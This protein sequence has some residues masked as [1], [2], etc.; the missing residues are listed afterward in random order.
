MQKKK[1]QTQKRQ[2]KD[3]NKTKVDET[4]KVDKNKIDKTTTKEKEKKNRKKYKIK[5]SSVLNTGKGRW[6]KAGLD[7]NIW[8][9]GRKGGK[10][11]KLNN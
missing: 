4:K 1:T 7:R 10:N 2:Q 8:S 3:K 6:T 9:E 11:V 5:Y